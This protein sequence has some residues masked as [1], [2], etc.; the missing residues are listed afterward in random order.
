MPDARKTG[1]RKNGGG[2][3]TL[4][5]DLLHQTA[6]SMKLPAALL[7]PELWASMARGGL[8]ANLMPAPCAASTV[9]TASSPPSPTP[10][11]A[12]AAWQSACV[13]AKEELKHHGHTALPTLHW[14][15]HGI[16]LSALS[17]TIDEL[18]VAGY[19]P[20]FIF[21]YDQAWQLCEKLFDAMERIMGEGVTLDVSVFAWALQRTDSVRGGVQSKKAEAAASRVGNNFG[22]PHR[23]SRYA[24][25][26]NANGQPTELA[27]WVPLVDVSTDNG[28]MMVVPAMHDPLFEKSDHPLHMKPSDTMPWAHIRALP[29]SAGD[30][31]IWRA[32]II[33]WGSACGAR[34]ATPRKSVAM[35]FTLQSDA[36]ETCVGG[37]IRRVD[38][39]A[40]LSMAQ[41]VKLIATSLLTYEHWH[42]KF[43]G[44]S[45][46]I[47][48][49]CLSTMA[50]PE[51]RA[52]GSAI[53]IPRAS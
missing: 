35:S 37:S 42:P 10:S 17:E 27:V 6:S 46:S 2:Y 7:Q 24:D 52:G 43:A 13:V 5:Q 45:T 44:L 49:S 51:V 31:L 19:P 8:T 25:C 26:H 20:V 1:G 14:S 50:F 38:L 3:T 12:C 53:Y 32:N 40:G 16:S 48:E 30:V 28:C 15:T 18:Q 23:D 11:S 4:V 22:V 39:R 29:A 21:M 33:H 41:R 34:A 47:V 36:D 9:G